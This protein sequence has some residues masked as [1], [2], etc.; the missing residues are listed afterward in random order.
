MLQ[1]FLRKSYQPQPRR[2]S[3]GV[4]ELSSLG[5][6]GPQCRS[7]NSVCGCNSIR[8]EGRKPE[9]ASRKTETR[10]ASPAT[11]GTPTDPDE[12]GSI[13][14]KRRVP[15]PKINVGEP[16]EGTA[17]EQILGSSRRK[18]PRSAR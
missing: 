17:D 3:C 4:H 6:A 13:C 12:N 1:C 11:A 10:N 16:H 5:H 14:Y 2:D 18:C 8:G 15:V 7:A 9:H